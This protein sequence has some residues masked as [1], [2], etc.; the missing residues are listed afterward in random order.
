MADL[1]DNGAAETASESQIGVAKGLV[2]AVALVGYL[3]LSAWVI[4]NAM[5]GVRTT[6]FSWEKLNPFAASSD[7]GCAGVL[8]DLDEESVNSGFDL[9]AV[10]LNHDCNNAFRPYRGAFKHVTALVEPDWW[11]ISYYQITLIDQDMSTENRE[12]QEFCDRGWGNITV[13]NTQVLSNSE[14]GFHEHCHAELVERSTRDFEH[15]FAVV[16]DQVRLIHSNYILESVMLHEASVSLTQIPYIFYQGG[17]EGVS[18]PKSIHSE[19]ENIRL[20]SD[21]DADIEIATMVPVVL[22]ALACALVGAVI[23][24]FYRYFHSGTLRDLSALAVTPVTGMFTGLLVLALA[25]LSHLGLSDASLSS[26]RPYA[27]ALLCGLGGLG[28]REALE[29]MIEKANSVF[30]RAQEPAS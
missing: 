28:G 12:V 3:A 15:F 18:L 27:L 20:E 5:P 29:M 25:V 21:P 16:R 4:A 11:M 9:M 22:T 17:Q 8:S 6:P 10:F 26:L 23:Q 2:V 7:A 1:D 14:H 19:F 30:G 24:L 13:E